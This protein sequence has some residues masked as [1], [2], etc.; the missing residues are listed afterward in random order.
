[1]AVTPASPAIP[2]AT[3]APP[4]DSG[5]INPTVVIFLSVVGG[6]IGIAI[7]AAVV[8]PLCLSRRSSKTR[9]TD[10]EKG[11]ANSWL[12]RHSGQIFDGRIPLLAQVPGHKPHYRLV[13]ETRPAQ[14]VDSVLDIVLQSTRDDME[15]GGGEVQKPRTSLVPRISLPIPSGSLSL[16]EIFGTQPEPEDHPPKRHA[17]KQHN[18]TSSQYLQVPTNKADVS[19]STTLSTVS[20][21]SQASEPTP[22]QGFATSSVST[23]PPPPLSLMNVRESERETQVEQRKERLWVQR[24]I[25]P[26]SRPTTKSSTRAS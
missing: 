19:R 12:A 11:L 17:A 18:G 3:K 6:V 4:V 2:S 26:A 25:P 8:L 20:A 14:P 21:Y 9:N 23:L 24:P 15:E 10:D 5:Y 7:L 16:K 22:Q 1:M 13:S